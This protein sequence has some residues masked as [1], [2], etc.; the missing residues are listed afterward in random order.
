MSKALGFLVNIIGFDPFLSF[1]F[2]FLEVEWSMLPI[3][4]YGFG[5]MC[6]LYNLDPPTN[7]QCLQPFIK[8]ILFELSMSKN[9]FFC[10]GPESDTRRCDSHYG[11]IIDNESIWLVVCGGGGAVVIMDWCGVGDW[12]I[13][14]LTPWKPGNWIILNI[15]YDVHQRWGHF[16]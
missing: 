14:A 6:T 11:Q 16:A 3:P 15:L 7:F 12:I 9:N 10:N 2:H 8:I 4:S 1:S 13:S 5:N